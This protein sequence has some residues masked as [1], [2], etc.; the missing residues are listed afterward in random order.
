MK[1]SVCLSLI[2][3]ANLF[4]WAAGAA[5]GGGA[6]PVTLNEET[7]GQHDMR[8]AWGRQA[9]FGMFIH[10]GLYSVA[11]GE[12]EGKPS[13]GAGE[14]IMN[15][16]QIPV[17]QY[18][19]LVPQFNPVKFDADQWVRLAKEAGMK[20]I[21]VTAKHH[22]GFGLF[23]SSLTDW[24]LKSTPFQREPLKELA[25][26]CRQEGI[27]LGFYYSNMDWHHPDYAPR[28]P[29][30]DGVTNA[31]DFD[32]YCA[33]L[34]GQLREL[35]SGYGPVSVLWFD[36]QW[37]NTWTYERG[38]EVDNYVR[39]LQPDV[40]VNNRVGTGLSLL[41]GQR[42]LGDYQTPEQSISANG[43]RAGVDWETCMTMNN[44]WGFKKG[45]NDWKSAQT[46]VRNLV[47]C[48]SKG[49]N[50]L[51]NIGPKGDGSIPDASVLRL[52]QIGKWMKVNGEAVWGTSA[53]PFKTALLWGRCT[54]KADG[55][56][57][58]LYLHVF[59]WPGDGELTVPGLRNQCTSAILLSDLRRRPLRTE[60]A[61]NGLLLTSLPKTPHDAISSTII[62]RILGAP[63]IQAIA[64]LQKRDGSITLPASQARLH[65]SSFQYESGGL[66]DNIGYWTTPEDWADWEFKVTQP[67]RFVLSAVVAAPAS[68][69]FEISV[70]GQT[71][72]CA[73][74]NTGNYVEFKPVELGQVEIPTAGKAM[75]TV[76]PIKEGWQ[77]MNLKAIRLERV[78]PAH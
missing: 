37:E 39:S 58:T 3:G 22:D 35:L 52:Q 67:G 8:M 5:T 19:R 15:D 60:T 77:P 14:W 41:A 49:G 76:R 6:V 7:Q 9:R 66:L 2:L 70:A 17:S 33:F 48:A 25:Q 1:H 23:R 18:A 59:D 29:W 46:L 61:E 65:G 13:A 11:A 43:L 38:V 54:T 63:D 10:W 71:L 78:A 50:Y 64:I 20:Y 42:T 68:G 40:I 73:A 53:S 26:A 12:W 34:K 21:V 31:P 75:L 74:P 32:R 28:K 55:E 51:L 57:T 44:T 30:N 45:D 4:G 72:R 62:V 16:L 24:C 69:S 36:G 47:D 27:K 56:A